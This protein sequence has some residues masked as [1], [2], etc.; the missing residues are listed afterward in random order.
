VIVPPTGRLCGAD[1][2]LLIL[3][4]TVDLPA[5]A[6]PALAPALTDRTAYSNRVTAIGYGVTTPQDEAGLTGGTR[7]IEQGVAIA[8]IS[9]ATTFADCLLDPAL[10][11][12]VAQGEFVSGGSSACAGDSGSGAFDQANFDQGRWIAVGIASRGSV[13]ADGT[14]CVN[15]V[16]TRLDTWAS[17]VVSAALQAAS[18][19]GYAPPAWAALPTDDEAGADAEA[20]EGSPPE[21]DGSDGSDEA[22]ANQP[23]ASTTDGALGDS[24]A[25]NAS[26]V[27]DGATAPP[28]AEPRVTGGCALAGPGPSESSDARLAAGWAIAVWGCRRRRGR[29]RA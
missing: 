14:T 2:A 3:D 25:S 18:A 4:R 5:Y 12:L 8:C 15:P 24:S 26:P 10:A 29:H 22:S 20:A 23:P 17:L 21:D 6:T 1:L 11:S 9:G 7:R 13:S 28:T 19:G 27:G 16:Y